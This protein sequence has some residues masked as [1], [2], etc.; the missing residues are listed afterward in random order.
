MCPTRRV[1]PEDEREQG[2]SDR[3]RES[4]VGRRQARVR[5]QIRVGRHER[6]G[7]RASAI[8]RE[9]PCPCPKD[10]AQ[11][12]KERQLPQASERQCGSIVRTMTE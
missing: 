2:R 1:E 12:Q 11:Q 3:R 9:L 10:A 8:V 4:D 6:Y 7:D 5:E